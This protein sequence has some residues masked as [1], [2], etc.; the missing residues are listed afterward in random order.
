MDS[1][2]T[3]ESGEAGVLPVSELSSVLSF[4]GSHGVYLIRS[5][6]GREVGSVELR[7]DEAGLRADFAAW[8]MDAFSVGRSRAEMMIPKFTL[9]RVA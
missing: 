5:L 8:I 6:R 1:T 3:R 9:E 2:G 4:G 7:G